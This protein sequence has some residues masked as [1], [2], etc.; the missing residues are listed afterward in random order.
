MKVIVRLVEKYIFNLRAALEV[1]MRERATLLA[2]Q[3]C[4][5]WCG[6]SFRRGAEKDSTIFH[7]SGSF[8]LWRAPIYF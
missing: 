4:A 3:V 8:S 2:T 5:P 7:A 1:E 6:V